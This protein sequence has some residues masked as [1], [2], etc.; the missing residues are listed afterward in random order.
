MNQLKQNESLVLFSLEVVESL[1]SCA[2]GAVRILGRGEELLLGKGSMEQVGLE[3]CL[4]QEQAEPFREEN[5]QG[6]FLEVGGVHQC[7]QVGIPLG[8]WLT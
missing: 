5:D 8:N 4:S 1:D 3:S 7:V 6:G 2:Y